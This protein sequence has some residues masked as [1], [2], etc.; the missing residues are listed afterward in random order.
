MFSIVVAVS[1]NNGIGY[2]GTIPWK[3]KEDMTFFKNLTSKL[4]ILIK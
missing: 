1:N 3:N 2:K 4:K